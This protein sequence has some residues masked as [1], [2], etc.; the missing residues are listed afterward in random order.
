MGKKV[1]VCHT[2]DLDPN[3]RDMNLE[4]RGCIYHPSRDWKSLKGLHCISYCNAEFLKALPEIK[5]YVRSTTFVNCMTFNF[6]LEIEMQKRGLI[7]FH[8]YQTEH[9]A[10][11]VGKGLRNS[12]GYRPIRYNPYFY[13]DEFPFREG[14]PADAFRFGRISRADPGK[15]SDRQLWIYETMTAPVPKAGLIMGWNGEVEK[16]MGRRPDSY[17]AAVDAG[18][19]SAQEFYRF[20]DAVIMAT[21]TVENLPRVG[22][23]AMAAGSVLVVDDRGG[24]RCQ[25]ESGI[26]GW[27]C[28]NDREFVYRATRL[29][30]EGAERD[31][32][33]L[34]AR[35]KL[36]REWGM[37]SAMDSWD[38][39]FRKWEEI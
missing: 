26:T 27:L 6:D 20:C 34:A 39:V 13:A 8:L 3:L 28:A 10:E 37:Q 15:F 21:D 19:T 33:R 4:A 38:R 24:W 11:R 29:A 9:G 36:Q 5:K 16:K 17:I 31:T 30:Y 2:G 35:E 25:V 1:H 14:R 22:F 7:D 23:E 12:K 18:W 32:F